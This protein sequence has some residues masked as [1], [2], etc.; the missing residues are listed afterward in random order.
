M[1]QS[2]V[3]GAMEAGLTRHE[4]LALSILNGFSLLDE[5]SPY[6][7]AY[8]WARQVVP[9]NPEDDC[10]SGSVI[11]RTPDCGREALARS[12]TLDAK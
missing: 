3:D 4:A 11:G 12:C 5:A 8:N 10:L 7:A 6:S 2:V 9:A 1:P